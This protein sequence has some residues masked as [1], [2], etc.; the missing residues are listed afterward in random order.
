M[1]K[2]GIVLRRWAR[3]ILRIHDTPHS[4][5]LGVSIGTFLGWGPLYGLHTILALVLAALSRCN[6]AA[7]VLVV[8]INN[9]ITIVPILYGQYRLGALLLPGERVHGAWPAI[10]RLAQ[11]LGQIS[12]LRFGESMK[13]LAE[14]VKGIGWDIFW[15]WLVGCLVSSTLL[16]VIAYPAV[17]RAVVRHRRKNHERREA[18]HRRLAAPASPAEQENGGK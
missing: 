12:L 4:I 18:R 9:P 10:K 3:R 8:W 11:S 17:Y 6:K 7:A 2:P 15:P 5:A 1:R 13:A 14:S 16:A